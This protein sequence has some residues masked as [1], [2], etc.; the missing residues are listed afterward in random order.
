MRT[1]RSLMLAGLISVMVI[2]CCKPCMGPGFDLKVPD[3]L[4][5][6]PTPLEEVDRQ[7]PPPPPPRFHV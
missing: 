1:L 7:L 4:M 3:N 5:V 2:G 6:P